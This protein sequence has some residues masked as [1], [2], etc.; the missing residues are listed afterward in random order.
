MFAIPPTNYRKEDGQLAYND[1]RNIK[2]VGW[3]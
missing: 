3:R 1:S 2:K